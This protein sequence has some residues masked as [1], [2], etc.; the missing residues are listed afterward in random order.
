MAGRD[1]LSDDP[2][3]VI[4]SNYSFLTDLGSYNSVT[5]TFTMW[6]GSEPDPDYVSERMAEVQ[7]RVAYSA[8]ILDYDYYRVVLGGD[9]S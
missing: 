6:D 1:I 8:S 4:F 5:D 2:G 7:N 9:S 3:L